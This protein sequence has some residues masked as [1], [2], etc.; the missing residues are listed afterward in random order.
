M[1][2]TLTL[3]LVLLT[4][5]IVAGVD[6]EAQL[7][8][9]VFKDYSPLLRPVLD[10]SRTVDVT[11]GM[12]LTHIVD[13][14]ELNEKL[15][16]NVWL[17]Q[18][19]VDERLRWNSSQY[20]GIDEIHVPSKR[21]WNPDI[22][23]YNEVR[24][25]AFKVKHTKVILKSDGSI[26]WPT[27]VL[28]VSTCKID[29]TQFPHDRQCC[30]LKF[31]SWTYHGLELNISA[32][33]NQ[34]DLS[35]YQTHS[36]WSLLKVPAYR[37]DRFYNCCSEPYPDVTYMIV[38]QRRL[39]YHVLKV[40]IPTAV[41]C[42]I[43][44]FAFYLP[45]ASGERVALSFTN[46]LT[47][48]VFKQV[49]MQSLPTSS[50]SIPLLGVYFACMI[51]IVGLSCIATVMVLNLYN[52]PPGYSEVPAIGKTCIKHLPRLVCRKRRARPA[53]FR[54][55]SFNPSLRRRTSHRLSSVIANAAGPNATMVFVS[56]H[57]GDSNAKHDFP[58]RGDTEHPANRRRDNNPDDRFKEV[59]KA[60]RHLYKSTRMT[61]KISRWKKNGKKSPMFST[62]SCFG[63]FCLVLLQRRL[64]SLWQ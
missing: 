31:G 15:T 41:I 17:R 48:F 53:T 27:P 44:L 18:F 42:V 11:H 61:K 25:D 1:I 28:L 13:F 12:S 8:K 2:S 22:T 32:E 60:F 36:G 34:V 50:E 46:L 19:W 9:D 55:R 33:D 7:L 20:D 39:T 14:D 40:I 64:V 51:V 26:K 54:R 52:V 49:M 3:L 29:V 6:Y 23:L 24:K 37:N 57:S 43:A 4:W 45:P 47:L 35:N 10:K 59:A 63:Y 21:V 62:D 30:P 38:L 58:S 56:D 16:V 5:Q